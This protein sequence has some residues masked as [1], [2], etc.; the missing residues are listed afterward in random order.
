LALDIPQDPGYE[1]NEIK[2]LGRRNALKIYNAIKEAIKN[3]FHGIDIDDELKQKL[4]T[5][6]S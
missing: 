3:D 2:S 5:I 6:Y 4:I 1:K